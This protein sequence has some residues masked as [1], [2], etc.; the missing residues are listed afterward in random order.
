MSAVRKPQKWMC[1]WWNLAWEPRKKIKRSKLLYIEV[2]KKFSWET[3]ELR[4]FNTVTSHHITHVSHHKSRITH[5]TPHITHITY[6]SHHSHHS[7]LTSHLTTSL[8]SHLTTS[9]TSHHTS[10]I[11]SQHITHIAH[12]ISPHYTSHITHITRST[13]MTHMT[14]ITYVT[15]HSHLTFRG[16][17]TIWR[18]WNA[19]WRQR[20]TA[21]GDVGICWNVTFR[22]RCSIWWCWSV[23]FRGRRS[24]FWRDRHVRSYKGLHSAPQDRDY[25]TVLCDRQ[26]R[27]YERVAFPQAFSGPSPP[28][29]LIT[30]VKY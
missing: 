27:S 24:I 14:R 29:H 7:H 3:S 20:G 10:H 16:R 1:L 9:L 13:H 28:R 8:T 25:T 15:H 6:I 21:F 18:C 23:T 12:H 19:F 26:A 17:R 11:T 2:S 22:G 5:L 4:R 30:K